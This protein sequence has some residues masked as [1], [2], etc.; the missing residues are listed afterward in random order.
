M[1]KVCVVLAL[2]GL[3]V[4]STTV[5]AQF[6]DSML[7]HESGTGFAA[8]F[9]NASAA[10][11][12]P[13]LGSSVTPLSPPFA[14]TQLV[15]IGAGGE[16]TLQMSSPILNTPANPYGL[17]FIIFA[18]SF[19]IQNGGSGQSATTS[20]SLFFHQNSALIQV[21]EDDVNWYTL[22]PALAPVPGEWF[23][24]YGGGN[25]LLP[26]D[27]SLMNSADFAG[28]TLAQVESLY[29]GSAGGTGY[30]LAWAQDSGGNSVDLTSVDYVQI[31]V[32]SGVLDLDAVSVVPEP[33]TWA[34]VFVGAGLFFYSRTAARERGPTTNNRKAQRTAQRAVPTLLALL[35]CL[36]TVS[37]A[38]AVT[39]TENF[40]NNP[41]QNGWQIFGNT[42]QFQWDST[43]HDMDVT[44]DSTQPN[45][46]FYRPLGTTL[47]L[48][49]SFT[50]SFDIQ[51]NDITYGS[52]PFFPMNLAVGLFNY[53]EA[54]NSSFSRP[55]GTTP[56][57]FEFDYFP[58]NGLGQ[59][60]LS[61][62]L[63]DDTINATNESDFYF[64]YDILPMQPGVNYQVTMTH[65]PGASNLCATVYNNGQVYTTMPNVFTAPMVDFHL[66]ALSISSYEED[67]TYPDNLLAHG[68][69]G[70]FVVTTTP[71]PVAGPI[72]ESENF[73]SNPLLAGWQEFG[74]TNLFTWDSTNEVMDVTWDSTN[75]NSYFYHPLGTTLRRDDDFTMTFDLNLSQAEASGF[76]FQLALGL[77]NL[78][79]ATNADFQR[80]TGE[81]SPD[82]VEF[83]Y[84]P[85][86]GFGPTVWPIFVDTNSLFNYN[87]TNDYASY[88]PNLNDWYHIVM[89]YSASNQIMVT[90][91]T[92]FEGTS[93]ITIVDPLMPTF[94]D[95]RV[96]TFSIS[97]YQDDGFGDSIYAQG[98][99]SNIV[100]TLPPVVRH[101]SD[102]YS[103]GVS[104][105][106]FVSYVNWNYMLERSTDLVSWQEI[107]QCVPGTGDVMTLSDTT[108]PGDK[109][110]YRV[111]ASQQ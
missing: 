102:S 67:A 76:G 17:D 31:D 46:Y 105:V 80:S 42:N 95:F 3:F 32:E 103:N 18:N 10:L 22:N 73:N 56:D 86:V 23:P 40:T 87:N 50:V 26:V 16:I 14:K 48:A 91:M 20:G 43:N 52:D 61:A 65:A 13:A 75:I 27:P 30:S 12:A 90:T 92:N 85:D 6:A 100:L 19:F 24:T 41:A 15:S 63:A 57:L 84:F 25:P 69:V 36:L 110:F 99:A 2:A 108:A 97:S 104:Q 33:A 39:L 59:P 53:N 8:G 98:Q 101:L 54:T 96:N 55:D 109:A 62:V 35:F 82:L 106:Q 1:K 72:V 64:I 70:N 45:S 34:M 49:D 37:S 93:G 83:D 38:R 44:W 29:N 11:G 94:T 7:S 74:D 21:S 66:D 4:M 51:L 58:D 78:S 28:L 47:T 88:A 60:N 111:L 71:A 89:T 81:N 107:S 68:T 5:Y 79:E 77:F 9:T